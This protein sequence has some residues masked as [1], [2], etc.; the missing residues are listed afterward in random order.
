MATGA[1]AQVTFNDPIEGN[2]TSAVIENQ[3]TF[4]SAKHVP[5]SFVTAINAATG[6]NLAFSTQSVALNG[7][8]SFLKYA[9]STFSSQG[10]L[11]LF[12]NTSNPNQPGKTLLD[13]VGILGARNGD[14]ELKIFRDDQIVF[15]M[16]GAG[17]WHYLSGTI[18]WNAGYNNTAWNLI[19]VSYGDQGMKMWIN[20]TAQT[21]FI[22]NS[23][24][25]AG[26]RSSGY[27]YVGDCARD[28]A[29][30]KLNG[31]NP[32]SGQPYDIHRGWVGNVDW[33]RTSDTQLDQ[34]LYTVPEPGSIVALLGGLLSTAAVIRRRRA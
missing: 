24:D 1:M 9:A 23:I 19:A 8:D 20:G 26:P 33:I 17:A 16:F 21:T 29:I 10:T 25:Y 6:Q 34:R 22:A 3:V 5:D 28:N 30:P 2:D 11:S 7:N 32:K 12:A 18:D 27:V 15:Q 31:I 13:T 4:D 14:M